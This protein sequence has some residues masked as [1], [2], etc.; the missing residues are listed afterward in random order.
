MYFSTR[1]GNGIRLERDSDPLAR[2]R[3]CRAELQGLLTNDRARVWFYGQA[4]EADF[5]LIHRAERESGMGD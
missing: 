2:R 1:R 5:F 3:L 4:A